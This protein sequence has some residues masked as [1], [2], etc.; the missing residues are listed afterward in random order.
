MS[1]KYSQELLE[2][3]IDKQEI[4]KVKGAEV[5]VKNIPD[6]DERGVMDPRFYNDMK[7]QMTLMKFMPKK[8]L[9]MDTS[10]KSIGKLRKMFGGIKSSPIVEKKIDIIHE[11]VEAADGYKV[12]VRIY[13]SETAKENSPILYYIHGGGFFGGSP[14]VVEELVKLIVEKTDILAVSVDYRLCPE[15]PYPI[16]H[17]DCYSVLKWIYDKAESLGGN[18]NNIFVA[19]DS[20]G[21]NLTQ[22]C[23]TKD[24]EQGL[25]MVTGQLLLYPTLN[26][27]NVEDEFFKW[28]RD[29]YEISPK[30]KS[31]IEM[32]LGMFEGLSGGLSD[33]LG[34]TD[35]KNEYLNPYIRDPKGLP[36]TFITV[37]EYDFL[38]VECLAYAAKLTKAGVETKTVLYKGLGHAY[39]DNVGVYP[40]SEDC[41]IEMGNFILKYSK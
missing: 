39:G 14:D 33:V 13:K 5:L 26:M 20:A 29:E 17:E 15:N 8:L 28:S 35:T 40:Q 36:P 38:K 41:A 30:Y 21:G 19:G 10:P 27:A 18:K 37:G 4:V 2:K 31:G 1:R 9:K 3:I 24:M 11:T 12:P 7:M 6:S 22:Y 25:G 16:G 23:T 34:T 32:M